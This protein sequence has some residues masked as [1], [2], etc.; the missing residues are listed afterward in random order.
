MIQAVSCIIK[1]F[2]FKLAFKLL[3]DLN[4][5][6]ILIIGQFLVKVIEVPHHEMITVISIIGEFQI[7]TNTRDDTALLPVVLVLC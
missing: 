5:L 2:Q 3:I 7:N 1:I 4:H 6:V